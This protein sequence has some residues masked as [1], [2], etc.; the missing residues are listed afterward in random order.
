MRH[1][2]TAKQQKF[3][4]SYVESGNATKAALSA[5]YSKKTAYQMGAENLKKPQIKATIKAHMARL[6]DAKIAKADEVLR[7]LTEVLRGEAVETIVLATGDGAATVVNP[8]SIKARLAAGKELLKRY[9]DN[10]QLL[11]AQ[12]AKLKA[13]ARKAKA[14]ADMAEAKAKQWLENGDTVEDAI[15]RYLDLLGGAIDGTKPAVHPET[16]SGAADSDKS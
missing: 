8:P 12:H 7:Y 6:E 4:D 10:D 15:S 9:P 13:D 16:D 2:L 14:E 11:K 5:G 3:V 1:K